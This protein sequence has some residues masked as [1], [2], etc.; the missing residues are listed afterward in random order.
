MAETSD[1]APKKSALKKWAILAIKL[2]ISAAGLYLVYGQLAGKDGLED[3]TTRLRELKWHWLAGAV[4]A[5][6]TAIGFA[7]GR[8]RV[9]LGGQGIHARLR[10]LIPSF[11]I[12]RF[13]GAFTPGGLG[14]DGWKLYDVA[15]QTKKNARAIAVT[16]A[17]KILGQL[18]FGIVVMGAS[19]WG[20][21]LVGVSGLVM[22]NVFFVVLVTCGLTFIARPKLF[23]PLFRLLPKQIESRIGGLIRA[24][25]AYHGKGRILA[26]AVLFGVAVHACNNL[27][28]VCASQ[29]IG[30]PVTPT[31]VFFA[32]SLVSMATIAPLSFNGVGVR[33]ATAAGVL[34]SIGGVTPGLAA[35]TY[36]LGWIA[37]MFVSAF[38]I[39]FFLA[40]RAGYDAKIVVDDADR[41]DVLEQE[42]PAIPM[43]K[44]PSRARGLAIGAGAGLLAGV[45]VGLAEG[46]FVVASGR[47]HVGYGV[48]AYGAVV[49]GL[50]CAFG[51][52]AMVLASAWL[53][54]LMKREAVPETH[55][56][57]RTTAFFIAL[58]ALALTAF[59][60]RRDVYHEELAWKS[61][62]GLLVLAACFAGAALL[63]FAIS[64]AVRS[65]TSG[66]FGRFVL[67]AWWGSPALA[68]V[69]IGALTVVALV[70]GTSATAETVERGR[71]PANAPNVLVIVVDTLRA[72]HLP[73]YGYER[74]RTPNLDRFAEDAIRFDRAYANASWTRPSFASILTGRYAS[75]HTVM[76]KE[77][78]G[79]ALP[80]AVA[81]RPEALRAGG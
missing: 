57:A 58:F 67:R 70:S 10:F 59:R 30:L 48:I 66:R 2:A 55:A 28:F 18:A 42:L 77:G 65:I 23:L 45:I 63:Y 16:T 81:T 22:I 73:A 5:Q 21:E 68:S 24:V 60:I 25:S 62:E 74:G 11:M 6:V 64:F 36:T 44:W 79:S 53:G 52:G 34:A 76:A 1:Q 40:R 39:P 35:A 3:L 9:M 49:Y 33:E 80:D 17:E 50:F 7:I 4:L 47:G 54:R 51:G 19:V 20:L 69:V 29:A 26:T 61:A 78:L 15:T 8:W 31:V 41:E 32:S 27:I 43:E 71:P 56:Y 13:W 72:D 14:L 46:T 75:S 37:E 12:G 38:G